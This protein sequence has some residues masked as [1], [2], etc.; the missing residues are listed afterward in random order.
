MRCWL[1]L[2]NLLDRES[3]VLDFAQWQ[4]SGILVNFPTIVGRRLHA[5]SIRWLAQQ[6]AH[7]RKKVERDGV[8][9]HRSI[10]E[11]DCRHSLELGFL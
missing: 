9:S 10:A 5:P 8:D 3:S 11:Y 1:G 4:G 2:L 6:M 7:L